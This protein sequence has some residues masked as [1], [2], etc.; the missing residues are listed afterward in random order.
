[1]I[2]K[3]GKAFDWVGRFVSAFLSREGGRGNVGRKVNNKI[4]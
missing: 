1:M 3:L 4:L 2:I